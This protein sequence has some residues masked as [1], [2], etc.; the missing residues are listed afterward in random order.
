MK[1]SYKAMLVAA[2]LPMLGIAPVVIDVRAQDALILAPVQAARLIP[3]HA[4][5][6]LIEMTTRAASSSG[7]DCV[8]CKL[9]ECVMATCAIGCPQFNQ[10]SS[11]PNDF[12]IVGHAAF[13]AL[14]PPHLE[15]LGLRP[16]IPPPRA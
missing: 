6:S 15:G 4:N 7:Q 3:L 13:A 12:A 9:A 10:I 2:L 1:A 14:P 5:A 11:A 8:C 16:P